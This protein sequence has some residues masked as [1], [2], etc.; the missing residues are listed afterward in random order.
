M[1]IAILTPSITTGDAVS[2][3][4]LG[5]YRVLQERHNVR[6]FAEGSSINEPR[7]LP[8]PRV[9]SFLG[10]PTDILIYHYSRGWKPGLEMLD[11]LSCRKVIKYHNVTP[12]EYM[13]AYSS[14]LAAMCLEGRRQLKPIAQSNCDLFL[15]ASAYNMEDL[16]AAGAPAEK[17]F[18]VAPF[19]Q[20]NRL[21]SVEAD[22]RVVNQ[23]QNG[24]VNIF[25]VGRIAPNKGHV[26]LIQAFAAYY[27]D[28]NAS[29]RL[30]IVGK[31]DT[32]LAKYS[33]LLR[34]LIRQLG[35]EH[36]IGFAGGVSD[37]E[38]KAYYSVADVFLT[39]SEHEG[40][41]VPLV[42]AMA[43]KLPIA[44]Y[45]SS[46]IPETVGPAGILWD[47][48]NPYLLAESIS[49]IVNDKGLARSLSAMGWRR[50]QQL[51]TNEQIRKQFVN[52]FDRILPN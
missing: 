50:Y 48:R 17:S 44:A 4:V 15:S 1:A 46:A 51:F 42:E 37:Q 39:T 21:N 40:F 19:H 22:A 31:E 10:K 18:V 9:K 23:Y 33:K 16:I 36:A 32:R 24:N 20:V 27:H 45:A 5:M 35:L 7:I 2:N 13:A 47:E 34:Q 14:D 6:I 28:Y 12:A 29:S 49:S 30:I 8:W 43:L 38:L 52:A 41:C 26:A 11:K 3:D 25:T